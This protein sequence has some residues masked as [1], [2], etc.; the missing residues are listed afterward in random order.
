MK[1]R[2]VT[3]RMSEA[4]HAAILAAATAAG[5]SMSEHLRQSAIGSTTTPRSVPQLNRLAWQ[6]LA[7][8]LNNLNQI[9]RAINRF[10]LHIRESGLSA[11]GI[12]SMFELM[13]VTRADVVALHEQIHA[14]R[15]ELFGS[16]PLEAAAATLEDFATASKARRLPVGGERLKAAADELR[17]LGRLLGEVAP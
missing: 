1:T 12:R 9:A 7:A 11:E 5:R 3:L 10:G 16:A 4:E 6:D 2:L 14:L 13:Q 17:E 8:P 15:R